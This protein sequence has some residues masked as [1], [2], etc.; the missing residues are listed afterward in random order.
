MPRFRPATR[1]QE[2]REYRAGLKTIGANIRNARLQKGMNQR[3]LA[4]KTGLSQSS[5]A[6]IEVRR[7]RIPLTAIY[8][9]AK[10]L[11]VPPY[12]LLMPGAFPDP[13]T[14]EKKARR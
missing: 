1:P 5:I 11:E 4:K 9:I 3:G 7:G 8:N 13:P 10:V 2:T 14:I 6:Q 12:M